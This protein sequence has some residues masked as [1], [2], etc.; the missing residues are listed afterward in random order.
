MRYIEHSRNHLS[1]W[2]VVLT[3]TTGCGQ[4]ILETELATPDVAEKTT[5]ST[6]KNTMDKKTDAVIE[7]TLEIPGEQN[8]RLNAFLFPS[9]DKIAAQPNAET[10]LYGK[11]L[12]ENTHI[13]LPNTV[14]ANINCTNCHLNAG[15]VPNAMP[16]VGV[17]DRYPKYRDRSGKEDNLAQRINGC[18][19]RSMNGTALTE[20]APEMLAMIAYMEWI[21]SDVVDGNHVDGVGLTKL[22][23]LTPDVDNGK[24]LYQA[25]CQFC[26]Q[27]DG[28]GLATPDGTRLYPPLWGE[29]AYNLGAGMAR[30]HT[31]AA[32]IK[33]NMPFGQGGS[34]S[35]QEAYDIAA[36]FST[37]ERPDFTYKTKDWPK[38]GKPDDARY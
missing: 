19:Q 35:D 4:S 14:T 11:R 2:T 24:L 1:A 31:A 17:D 33:W 32:F 23:P 28:T 22:T 13:E 36:Y 38:G 5:V 8:V 12:I 34:L 37:Q 6:I 30:L 20:D 27:A 16:F 7:Q 26:H 18:F 15:T 9:S 3:L 21:S 10:I 29:F 25:K